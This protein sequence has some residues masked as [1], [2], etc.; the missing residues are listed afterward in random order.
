MVAVLLVLEIFFMISQPFFKSSCGKSEQFL[1]K[2]ELRKICNKNNVK[3]SYSCMVNVSSK[4]ARRNKSLLQPQIT[5]YGCNCRVKNTCPLQ[6][7]C[8][9]QNLIYRADVENEINNEKRYISDLLQQL[10]ENSLEIIKKI[11]TTSNTAKILS[12]QNLC[13]H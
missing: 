10:L 4:I 2:N 8:Q 3:I 11:S 12:C 9:T 1:K 6:T 13:G 7:Q 5:K